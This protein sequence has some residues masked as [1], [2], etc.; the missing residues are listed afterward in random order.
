[1]LTIMAYLAQNLTVYADQCGYEDI[2]A[3]MWGRYRVIE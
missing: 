1:M 2:M 3:Q